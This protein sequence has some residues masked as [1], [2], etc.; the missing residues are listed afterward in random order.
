MAGLEDVLPRDGSEAR[1]VVAVA[2]HNELVDVPPGLDLYSYGI[3][4]MAY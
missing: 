4:V 3:L 1:K 2:V